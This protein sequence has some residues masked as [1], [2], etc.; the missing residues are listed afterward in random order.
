MMQVVTA[1]FLYYMRCL[2]MT[3]SGLG[4]TSVIL[5]ICKLGTCS[6]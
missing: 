6:C 2:D 5:T 4:F 1:V 3:C